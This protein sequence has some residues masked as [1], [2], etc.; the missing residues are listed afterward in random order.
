V[1][2]SLTLRTVNCS[3]NFYQSTAACN[4]RNM[5][6]CNNILICWVYCGSAGQFCFD[7]RC[8]PPLFAHC[9]SD[10]SAV[11]CPA[12]E[13][14]SVRLCSFCTDLL[15]CWKMQTVQ[16]V[17]YTAGGGGG[18]STGT[19]VGSTY[20][21]WQKCGDISGTWHFSI[22][23]GGVCPDVSKGLYAVFFLGKQSKSSGFVRLHAHW[24]C[25]Q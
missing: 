24:R 18:A 21:I 2:S 20:C 13:T 5:W 15:T 3:S 25:R 11:W 12:V 16:C 10:Y 23:I 7:C 6:L 8:R 4:S 14:G 1:P 19:A 22:A 9:V 17:C